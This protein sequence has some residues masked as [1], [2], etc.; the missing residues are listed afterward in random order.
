M[1]NQGGDTA[2]AAPASGG[3]SY[4]PN[5]QRPL[6][7]C[8]ATASCTHPGLQS[9]GQSNYK[10]YKDRLATFRTW[11]KAMPISSKEMAHAGFVYT[12]FADKV[13]CPWCKIALHE[14]EKCDSP[15]EEHIKHSSGCN[16]LLIT[17][18]VRVTELC[19]SLRSNN[20]IRRGLF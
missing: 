20:S 17:G 12:G 8:E 2:D 13:F 18:P 1:S 6:S 9:I 11:P 16:Y 19:S 15:F 3:F 7:S 4:G 5:L 10:M 14:F